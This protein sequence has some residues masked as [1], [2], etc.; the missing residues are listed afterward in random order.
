MLNPVE[1]GERARALLE[2]GLLRE[3]LDGLDAHY[4]QAWRQARTVEAREDCH[5]YVLLTEKLIADLTSIATTGAL[6]R[7]RLAELEGARRF[8]LPW[9]KL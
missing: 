5:R 6:E 4:T 9:P 8:V 2:N 3:A 7:E 1:R